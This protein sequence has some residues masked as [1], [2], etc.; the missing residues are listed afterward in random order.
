MDHARSRLPEVKDGYRKPFHVELATASRQ[1]SAEELSR[2][3]V[4]RR[5]Q[6]RRSRRRPTA[7]RGA[8]DRRARALGIRTWRGTPTIASWDQMRRVMDLRR[9]PVGHHWAA[10]SLVLAEG[11]EFFESVT[12]GKPG[13]ALV[14]LRDCG[15]DWQRMHSSREM[16]RACEAAKVTPPVRFHDLRRSYGSLLLNRGADAAVIQ[17][18]LGHADLRMTRRAYAH[19]LNA[20]VARTVKKKLP[21]FGLERTNVRKLRP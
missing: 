10:E 7:R 11:V 6:I 1:H 19:L 5:T 3:F 4:V 21:S 13:D 18:L 12:V 9:N 2:A 14:F 15:E 16:R 8:H 20:T 17:E